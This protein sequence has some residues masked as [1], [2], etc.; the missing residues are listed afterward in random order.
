MKKALEIELNRYIKLRKSQ[1][2]CSGFIDGFK[3]GYKARTRKSVFIRVINI[4]RLKL[5]KPPTK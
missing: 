1:E 5:T 3:L 4:L 2:E